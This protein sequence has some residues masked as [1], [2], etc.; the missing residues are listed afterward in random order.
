MDFSNSKIH[1]TSINVDEYII[2]VFLLYNNNKVK[3][4]D[5]SLPNYYRFN[6]KDIGVKDEA[7]ELS[8]VIVN[9]IQLTIKIIFKNKYF[10]QKISFKDRINFFNKPKSEDTKKPEVPKYTPN[11]LK[12][13][14]I[15]QFEENK[16]EEPTKEKQQKEPKK[17]IEQ[18]KPE[19]PPKE[20]EKTQIQ[21]N[22]T[23]A[24]KEIG[25]K[26]EPPKEEEKAPE[27][28]A[29]EIPKQEKEEPPKKE[30]EE[31]PKEENNEK[32]KEEKEEAPKEEKKEKPQEESKETTKNEEI[33][34][35]GSFGEEEVKN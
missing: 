15:S 14:N 35:K 20:E 33:K 23:E 34:V 28:E 24:K 19:E 17:E 10:T 8:F 12:A 25:K 32:P 7:Q 13:T 26:T 3:S 29:K 16:K 6:T 1:F 4:A 30:V 9:G 11:K 31:P 18:P 22:E 21:N 27:Q 2:D 5:P